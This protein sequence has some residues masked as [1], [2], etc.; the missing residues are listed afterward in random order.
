MREEE[1]EGR[2]RRRENKDRESRGVGIGGQ[3]G[4]KR[5]VLR[6]CCELYP[7]VSRWALVLSCV[8][9]SPDTPLSVRHTAWLFCCLRARTNYYSLWKETT[10]AALRLASLLEEREATLSRYN[11][12]RDFGHGSPHFENNLPTCI[13]ALFSLSR[14]AHDR[15]GVY[16][17]FRLF[18]RPRK[19][20]LLLSGIDFARRG[21]MHLGGTFSR[22]IREKILK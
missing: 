17:V 22:Q 12:H 20:F 18:A 16:I 7:G 13:L 21:R 5:G 19:C 9:Y 4:K 6:V 1:R 15:R 2:G 14:P 11:I 3:E 10:G 8:Y